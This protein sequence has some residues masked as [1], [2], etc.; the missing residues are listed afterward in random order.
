MKKGFTMME[1]IFVI[2]VLGILAVIAIPR[3]A[4]SRDDAKLVT[5]KTDIGVFLRAVPAWYQGQ[6]D[7]RINQAANFDTK[8]W[9]KSTNANDEAYTFSLDGQECVTVA[10]WDMNTT[11][12]ATATVSDTAQLGTDINATNGHWSGSADFSP[13]FRVI[14]GPNDPTTGYTATSI[15]DRLWNEM[16]V[17]EVNI[18]MGAKKVN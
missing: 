12:G 11:I 2:V 1:L 7:A 8:K 14:K 18:T 6:R 15:C 16:K 10:I 13:V 4:A 9:L 17:T 5:V 3:L